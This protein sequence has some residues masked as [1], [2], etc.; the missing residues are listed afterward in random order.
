MVNNLANTDEAHNNYN[1]TVELKKVAITSVW[2]LAKTLKECREQKYW[3]ALGYQ[4]FA[5]YLAQPELDLN[6]HTVNNWITILNRFEENR[7]VLPEVL[8]ISKVAL[9][10]PHITPENADELITKAQTLSRSDLR[11]ELPIE[12]KPL[13]QCICPTC[14]NKHYE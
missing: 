6:E 14:G 4:S 10:A 8:D 7:V 9:I 3:E 13:K 1:H 11:A 12:T 2:E 5:S